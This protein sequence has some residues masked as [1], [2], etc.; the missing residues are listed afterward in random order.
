MH[1]L[2]IL[3]KAFKYRPFSLREAKKAGISNYQ[4]NKLISKEMVERIARGI[5]KISKVDTSQ[6]E[7]FK[8]AT[9]IIGKSCVICLLSA[10][11]YYDLTDI[12][13]KEVWLMVPSNKRTRRANLKLFRTSKPNF[14]IGI[15]DD[16]GFKITSIERT[17]VDSLTHERQIASVIGIEAMRRAIA[18]KKTTLSKIYE[19]S[20]KLGSDHRIKNYIEALS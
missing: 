17:I 14:H 15:N 20:K 12:I 3:K 8:Q 11:E 18:T 16:D 2:K 7:E 19:V 10:L 6:I 4:I 5:Y 9:A 13:S 1:S